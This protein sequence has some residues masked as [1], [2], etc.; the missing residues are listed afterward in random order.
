[1]LESIFGKDAQCLGMPLKCLLIAGLLLYVI[2]PIDFLPE[3]FLGPIGLIDDA[4]ALLL[5]FV[6]GSKDL[7]GKLGGMFK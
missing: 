5:V 1:M 6:L 7:F 3:L 4:F 2:S